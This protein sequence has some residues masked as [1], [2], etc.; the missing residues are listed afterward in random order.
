MV[1]ILG[2]PRFYDNLTT[3]WP[4]MATAVHLLTDNSK[5]KVVSSLKKAYPSE[6]V[7]TLN[8]AGNVEFLTPPC[9]TL[10]ID[11]V[12]EA[13]SADFWP[14]SRPARSQKPAHPSRSAYLSVPI[15]WLLPCRSFCGCGPFTG[16][17]NVLQ[18]VF[19]LFCI[20][21]DLVCSRRRW[22]K[23]RAQLF[24]HNSESTVPA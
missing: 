12:G 13:K 7:S 5:T 3:K 22:Q 19:P 6:G 15:Q 23:T 8:V 16:R 21:K 1:C 9:S 17:G 2:Y 11:K 24:G 4:K 14:F 18:S 10:Q 20:D